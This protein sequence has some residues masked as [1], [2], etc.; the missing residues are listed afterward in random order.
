MRPFIFSETNK[1]KQDELQFRC[2]H[3]GKKPYEK[4]FPTKWIESNKIR[5]PKDGI[6][7]P[8][9]KQEDPGQDWLS[10]DIQKIKCSDGKE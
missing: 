2:F 8:L 10:Y 6:P 9:E 7:G 5:I 1:Y 3:K 4:V